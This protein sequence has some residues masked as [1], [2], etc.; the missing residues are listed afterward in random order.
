MSHILHRARSRRQE[1]RRIL[2]AGDGQQ[3]LRSLAAG[4]AASGAGWYALL[5]LSLYAGLDEAT[6]YILSVIGPDVSS[7]IGVSPSTFANLVQQRQTL[8]GLTAIGFAQNFWKRQDRAKMSKFMGIQYGQSLM[9]GSIITWT[10][11]MSGAVGGAGGGAGAVWAAHRPL[12]MDS[13]PPDVRVRA[14]S[15][16]R[17]AGVVGTIAGTGLLAVLTGVAGLTWRGAMLLMG[18]PFLLVALVG[19]RLRDPGY[20]RHDSDRIAG[21]M[22]EGGGDLPARVNDPSELK[23]LEAVRRVWLIPTVRRLLAAW[24]VLGV[25]V[26]PVVTYQGFWLKE[27]FSLTTGQRAAFF[28]GSWCLAL[29]ALWFMSRAGERAWRQDPTRLVRLT[30]AGLVALAVGL[31]LA[32]IPVLALSFVGFA[33]AFAAEAVAVAMLSLVVMTAV[34]P[35]ARS[36][37]I[38]LAAIFFGLVG[39]EGGAL[40]LGSVASRYSAAIAIAVLAAPALGA[41]A[42]L[43]KS[44]VVLEADLDAVVDEILEDEGV[45]AAVHAGRALPLLAC[46]GVDFSYGRLQVLFGVDFTVRDGEI[47][48]LL[49]V[50][51]AG[52]SSLLKVISGIGLPSAGSVRL[53]GTDITYLDAERRVRLGVTQIPGGRAVFGPLT[54]AENLRGLGYTLGRDKRRLDGAIDECFEMFPVLEARRNQLASTLSGGEQQ[55]LGLSKAFILKPELLLIDELSLGLAPVIVD[56]L[57]AMVRRINSDGTAVVLVEQSVSI[58]LGV[59]NHAYFM[60]KGQVRFDGSARDLMGRDDLIR[61]VFLGAA[62]HGGSL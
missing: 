20:G 43:R 42:L 62:T 55:M 14:L 36:I 33:V 8:V 32:I 13:Y 3:P 5:V 7:A 27:Q 48:A 17:G 2:N 29:P 11:A 31:L 34:R 10:P 22:H 60:E 41:A 51:G 12:I 40:V 39:G 38:S 52:K 54:V 57:L 44:S 49:G 15:F 28:A 35:R 30:A 46:R 18:V 9:V 1:G 45:H 23:F 56:R 47:L 50:N 6:G 61:A 24:A 16:H 4:V 58:A 53:K 37:A 59:A 26:N 21:L 19:L 25:A